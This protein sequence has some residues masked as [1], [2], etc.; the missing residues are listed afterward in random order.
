MIK[1][2]EDLVL[3]REAVTSTFAI[4]AIRG[5]GKSNTARRMAEGMFREGLQ[6][7]V[8][9]PVGSWWGLRSSRD[10][11]SEGLPITIFGGEHAD[12]P[13]EPGGA[14]IIV[15]LITKERLSCIIDMR[16]LDHRKGA[17]LL[18][19]ATQLYRNN[20]TPCHLFLEEADDFIPQ[21]PMR[22]EARMLRAWEDIVRRGRGRGLG[23]T[24][25]TQRSAALHGRAVS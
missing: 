12:V 17:F 11:K 2:A 16:F 13:L 10:G 21:R 14:S 15:D 7:V 4:L 8:I 3:P 18:E 25:I 5:A 22:D 23:I 1:L 6:I 19:F 24:M 9:D 20:K